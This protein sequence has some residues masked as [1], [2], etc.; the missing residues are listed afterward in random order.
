[1]TPKEAYALLGLPLGSGEHEIRSSLFRQY[2][3]VTDQLAH[4]DDERR[5]SLLEA[6]MERLNQAS[7]VLLAQTQPP[8][9]DA[10]SAGSHLRAIDRDQLP[11]SILVLVYQTQGQE[12]IHTLQVQDQD[13]VLG[14]ESAFGAR[15]YA[16]QLG[17]QGLPKPVAERFATQEI[18][19]FCQSAGYGLMV[20]PESETVE[21]PKTHTDTIHD[22]D[23]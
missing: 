3:E 21:P 16:Q 10:K 2:Q 6:Q 14:F 13:I 1:M 19:E 20:I 7:E 12:G 4:L 22:W 11:D 5:R 15:K 23:S 9:G 17:R 18:V 8:P